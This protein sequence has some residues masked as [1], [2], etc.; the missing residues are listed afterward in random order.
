MG[1]ISFGGAIVLLGGL[2]INRWGLVVMSGDLYLDFGPLIVIAC[3]LSLLMSIIIIVPLTIIAVPL[4]TLFK[5]PPIVGLTATSRIKTVLMVERVIG[6]SVLILAAL[7]LL[8][9]YAVYHNL[10]FLG[11]TSQ[12]QGM[13]FLLGLCLVSFSFSEVVSGF[14]LVRRRYVDSE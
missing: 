6:V 9:F 3:V 14:F 12:P 1:G 2:A 13:R 8:L 7:S 11:A 5:K 10:V 4:T